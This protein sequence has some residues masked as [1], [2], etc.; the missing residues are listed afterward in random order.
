MWATG[1]IEALFAG[2]IATAAA[3]EKAGRT[4][5]RSTVKG[6]ELEE[7]ELRGRVIDS[8]GW[9][10]SG[11]SIETA[12]MLEDSVLSDKDGFFQLSVKGAWLRQLSA[13]AEGKGRSTSAALPGEPALLVLAPEYPW[14]TDSSEPVA[15]GQEKAGNENMLA[16]EGNLVDTE[17]REL[18]R[19]LVL[20]LETGECVR[21]DEFG[22]FRLPLPAG[23]CSLMAYD[24]QGRVGQITINPSGNLGLMPVGEIELDY[25]VDLAGI[26]QDK[27]SAPAQIAAVE[28]RRDGM[29]RRQ[30]TD[31]SGRFAF[32]GLL[33]GEYELIAYPHRGDLGFR[34]TISLDRDTDMDWTLR[35]S[36]SLRI[37]VLDGAAGPQALAHVL[38]D[39]EGFGL[40]YS[41]AD[42]EGFV[43][44]E[45]LG[46]GPYAFEVRDQDL[47]ELEVVGYEA[48]LAKLM[49]SASASPRE[50]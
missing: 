7:A 19:A 1:A 18:P 30:F 6:P 39:Q 32:T 50:R 2:P 9:P 40:H 22:R 47:G 25:G 34:E 41:Q 5:Q 10:V 15:M 13:A 26:L 27:E 21:A 48:E 28:L 8:L 12:G 46:K 35:A 20:V 36:Q 17:G 3:E 23:R 29:R 45:G 14:A 43:L 24:D 49:V 38:L 33:P 31:Q 37:Q 11:A 4:V 44:F 42:D 16:G